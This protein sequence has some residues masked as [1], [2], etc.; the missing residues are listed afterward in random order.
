MVKDPIVEEI[1]RVRDAQAKRFDYDL[2]AICDNLSRRREILRQQG[3]KFAK[4]PR[5]RTT[6]KLAA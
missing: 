4:S 1:H 5:R 6:R 2:D 3:W